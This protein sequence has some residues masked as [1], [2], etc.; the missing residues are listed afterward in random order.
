MKGTIFN[1]QK[2]CVNDGTGIRTV[3]FLKG[4][5]LNCVWCHNP[6]SR[7]ATPQIMFRKDKCTGCK[8]C[9]AVCPNGCHLFTGDTHIFERQNCS[10]CFLC[11]ET[12]CEALERVGREVSADEVIA[13]AMKDKIFY[14]NSGGGITLSGGEPLYRFGFAAEIL[15]KAKENGLHTAIETCGFTSEENIRK[16]SEYVD[17]FLFD[18]KETNAKLHKAFTGVDNDVIVG[19]LSLLNDMGKSIVLRC[20]IIPDCN[21]RKEHF[22]GICN[23]ANKFENILR[24]E[25]EPYHSLGED[26]YAALGSA[27][28]KFRTPS[29]DEKEKWLSEIRSGTDKKVVFA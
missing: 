11:A 1:I 13:E 27:V 25:I 20:P 14:D 9:A 22:E 19:N 17:L 23:A 24:V 29:E 3:V 10:E 6:E 12:G 4:C 26:K 8:R 2:F 28:R 16:I 21:D 7:S 18:Y 15:K 5:P